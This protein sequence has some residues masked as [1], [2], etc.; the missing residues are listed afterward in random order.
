[1]SRSHASP[2][3]QRSSQLSEPFLPVRPE[4]HPKRNQARQ[5]LATLPTQRFRDL[6]SDVYFELDRRYPEFGDGEV[7]GLALLSAGRSKSSSFQLQKIADSSSP[8]PTAPTR[9][10]RGPFALPLPILRL[11]QLQLHHLSQPTLIHHL[12]ASLPLSLQLP[13]LSQPEPTR[14]SPRRASSSSRSDASIHQQH[15]RRRGEFE[16]YRRTE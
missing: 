7:S 5:K 11:E 13:L 15:R 2:N 4:F 3:L 9:N 12:P 1:M 14:P 16:R 6:A 10:S 8:R